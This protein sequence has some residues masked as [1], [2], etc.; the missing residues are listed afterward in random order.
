MRSNHVVCTTL[1]GVLA[2]SHGV[3]QT[4]ALT[5]RDDH[6]FGSV[7]SAS[8]HFSLG[9][10][11]AF[12]TRDLS[13]VGLAALTMYKP[14]EPHDQIAFVPFGFDRNVSNS[15]GRS[16]GRESPGSRIH[17]ARIQTAIFVGHLGLTA[18]VDIAT[19]AEI[20]SRDYE[21]PFV[22]AKTMLY[23]YGI[24]EVS[25]NLVYRVRPDGSDS[26]AFFSGHASGS[27]AASAFVYRELDDWIDGWGI[28]RRSDFTRTLLK[29]TA[30]AAT[31]GWATY[32]GYSRIHDRKHYLSDV[33]VGAAVGT[34]LG[35]LMY[36]WHFGAEDLSSP[37]GFQFSF[38][39]SSQPAVGVAYHF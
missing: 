24:T 27:F 22:F 31:Y 28:A 23:T 33:L 16:D 17:P 29:S 37:S 32:V 9:L 12:S 34:V 18:L 35:N 3:G 10:T 39:P 14:D 19:D 5:G 1:L 21:R 38:I 7:S 15:L 13:L 11:D 25:K 8:A 20:T 30:F 2:V 36:D 4:S 6:F 26:R